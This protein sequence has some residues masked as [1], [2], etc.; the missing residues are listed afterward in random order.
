MATEPARA[1][2]VARLVDA[3]DLHIAG[4]AAAPLVL[5]AIL[6]HAWVP[7]GVAVLPLGRLLTRASD[8][9]ASGKPIGPHL[10]ANGLLVAL[11]TALAFVISPA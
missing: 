9:R 3:I 8:L 4:I 11:A 6:P 7:W 5:A 2:F 1:S 10:L